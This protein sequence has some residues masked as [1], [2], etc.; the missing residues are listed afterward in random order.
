M[1]S[2]VVDMGGLFK[3]T[4]RSQEFSQYF[5]SYPDELM[6]KILAFCRINNKRGR[7]ALDVACGTGISTRILSNHFDEVIGC[8]IS[9]SQINE[10][11]KVETATNVVYRVAPAE[12]LPVDSSSVDLITIASSIHLLPD[13]QTFFSE[14]DRVLKPGGCLAMYQSRPTVLSCSDRSEDMAS[15]L[16]YYLFRELAQYQQPHFQLV[17]N[18]YRDIELPYSDEERNY[19]L[20]IV[21]NTTVPDFIRSWEILSVYRSYMEN[22]P[23]KCNTRISEEIQEKMM[24]VLGVD[25]TPEETSIT[26]NFPMVLAM[27][28]K[29]MT[30]VHL[31]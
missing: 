25:T 18:D 24:S 20:S 9:E 17:E 4:Q 31:D 5:P 16:H 13:R 8:D 10:A 1:A 12:D 29:P 7:M 28:R 3:S 26:T 23:A 30:D 22:N 27:C 2:V 6:E 11:K 21:Y 15:L 19:R 14:V